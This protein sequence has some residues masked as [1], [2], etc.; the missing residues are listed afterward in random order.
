VFDGLVVPCEVTGQQ[1][2]LF[3][4]LGVVVPKVSE[5]LEHL[6]FS[7]TTFMMPI[8]YGV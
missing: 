5:N 6:L 3:E 1:R 2:I 8:T 7:A 4:T